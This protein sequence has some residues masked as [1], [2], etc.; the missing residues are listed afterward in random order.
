MIA[1]NHYQAVETHEDCSTVFN[2]LH[3]SRAARNDLTDDFE[4]LSQWWKLRRKILDQAL[5]EPG[6]PKANRAVEIS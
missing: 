3:E 5:A 1:Y 4:Q 6:A 2:N